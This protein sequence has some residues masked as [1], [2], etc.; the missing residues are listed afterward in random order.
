MRTCLAQGCWAK[1]R[2][3]LVG[4]MG[5]GVMKDCRA[6]VVPLDFLKYRFVTFHAGRCC[7]ARLACRQILLTACCSAS[8]SRERAFYT[9][10]THANTSPRSCRFF[11][12]RFF[13]R[14]RRSCRFCITDSEDR[15]DERPQQ[16]RPLPGPPR[17]FHKIGPLA[18]NVIVFCRKNSRQ[19]RSYHQFSDVATGIALPCLALG[20]Q[21]I[22]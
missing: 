7:F 19:V 18:R 4:A 8:I 10:A 22:D 5:C 3:A 2:A 13:G 6:A 20:L 11:Q 12:R 15:S 9:L 14:F 17:G 1:P 16:V 21:K